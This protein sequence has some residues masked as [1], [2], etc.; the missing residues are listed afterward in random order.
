[1]SGYVHAAYVDA[2]G[3]PDAIRYGTLPQPRPADGEVLVRVEATTVNHVDTFIRSGAFRTPMTFPFVLGRD[4]VGTVVEPAAGFATGERVWCNSMGHDGRQGAAASGVAVPADRLYRLPDG[5]SADDVV[6]VAH[7]AATA[8]L[9]LFTHGRLRAGETVVVIG[10]AGNVG[11][12]IVALAAAAGARVV[13]VAG[14]ADAAYCRGIG[15]AEVVDRADPARARRL[16]AACPD[17]VDL[18][19]DPAGVNDL[20]TAVGLLA[21]GGRIVLLAGMA[22][23]PVLPVGPLYT[24]NAAIH[25]F[26]ISHAT[27]A[28]LAEAAAEIGRRVATGVLRPRDILELPLGEAERAHRAVAS[29]ETK[30]RRVVLRMPT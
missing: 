5:V 13:A 2:L 28:E 15:A 6:A 21:R 9:G 26:V 29:G 8:Y 18:Y 23:R 7:P 14:A 24:N 27:A 3:G 16:G 12:A 1:M 25:G 11:G 20:D 10:A 4:L 30:G 22:T 19:I 17:G